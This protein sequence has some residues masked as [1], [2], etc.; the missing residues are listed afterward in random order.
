[1]NS[2]QRLFHSI[3]FGSLSVISLFFVWTLW[4]TFLNGFGVPD[5]AVFIFSIIASVYS[6]YLAVNWIK[7]ARAGKN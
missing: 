1:M 2:K 5:F 3:G 6:C 7:N 4:L